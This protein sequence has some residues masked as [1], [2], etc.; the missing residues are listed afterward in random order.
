MQV[1]EA[2]GEEHLLAGFHFWPPAQGWDWLAWMIPISQGSHTAAAH[3][4][5][6]FQ[7]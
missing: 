7:F 6:L 3:Q 4:E 5:S 2:E 1:L